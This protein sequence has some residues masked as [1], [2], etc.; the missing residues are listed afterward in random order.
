MMQLAYYK[1]QTDWTVYNLQKN[2]QENAFIQIWIG[3]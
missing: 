2:L 3:N 1:T